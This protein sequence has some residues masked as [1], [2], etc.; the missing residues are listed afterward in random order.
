M[1]FRF[2]GNLENLVRP[3]HDRGTLY[4][5]DTPTT[6]AVH[7]INASSQPKKFVCRVS[8]ETKVSSSHAGTHVDLEPHFF[9]DAVSGIFLPEKFCGNAVLIDV[10]N[11]LDATM[12][13]SRELLRAKLAEFGLTPTSQSEKPLC[14][15]VK[16]WTLY[17][18]EPPEIFPFFS[19]AAAQLLVD[20]GVDSVM[21]DTVS[22]D[23]FGEADLAKG[24]H[25][26]FGRGKV[27]IMEGA[28]LR[29]PR[30]GRGKVFTSADINRCNP[31]AQGIGGLY[32][33]PGA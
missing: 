15:M 28:N 4:P 12:E 20:Y 18:V 17:P 3:V 11:Q 7:T 30:P 27:G 19:P 1:E 2:S 29:P 8:S 24:A 10:S 21:T 26:I 22:V 6:T 33:F 5:G 23:P 14:V 31:D 16:T 9:R 13:I 25:G 32:F